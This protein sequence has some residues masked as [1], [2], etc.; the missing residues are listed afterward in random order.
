MRTFKYII[1]LIA[2]LLSTKNIKAQIPVN[3][4]AWIKQTSFSDEFNASYLDTTHLW[5]HG[6]EGWQGDGAA[7]YYTTN[8][9][10]T[11]T[12]LK[13]KCDSLP[14]SKWVTKKDKTKSL[15]PDSMVS[16][17]YTGDRIWTDTNHLIKYG[18]IEINAKFPKYHSFEWPAFWMWSDTVNCADSTKS[19]YNEIDMVENAGNISYHGQSGSNILVNALTPDC[20]HLNNI[21]F[22]RI[23]N[24][25]TNNAPLL[26]TNFHKFAIQWDP[27]A[28]TYYYDDI[29]WRTITTNVPK[30]A[31]SITLEFRP[32][33]WS[34]ILP[35]NWDRDPN[36]VYWYDQ[37]GDFHT[38]QYNVW[39]SLRPTGFN[40]GPKYFEIEHLYCYKLNT[41]CSNTKTI[42]N[43][44]T[45]YDT[46]AN[47][48]AVYKSITA[49]GTSCTPTF[50]TSNGFTL[51]ATDYVILDVGTTV[52][53]NGS[54]QFSVIIQSCPQ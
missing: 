36:P 37:T 29:P 25:Q 52:N 33:P 31:Q 20:S 1:L 40:L 23:T 2:M 50:N 43:P 30:H 48:R 35:P 49:G 44:I 9:S 26:D 10:F 17:A 21:N 16:Y 19:F 11:G 6:F 45:D 15:F 53:P 51:R 28:L 12:T 13:I 39:D 38:H 22:G 14:P 54:G 32:Y 8:L 24:P 46:G 34:V 5:A 27:G 42:C 3:D 4:S 7:V 41:Q 18:Y 47:K